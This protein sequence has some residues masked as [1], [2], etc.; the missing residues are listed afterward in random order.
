MC[1]LRELVSGEATTAPSVIAAPNMP[2]AMTAAQANL[3]LQLARH[4][5]DIPCPSLQLMFAGDLSHS[6]CNC[7]ITQVVRFAHLEC[8]GVRHCMPSTTTINGRRPQAC[9]SIDC[10]SE[11]RGQKARPRR[12]H[13]TTDSAKTAVTPTL[14]K[15]NSLPEDL[16]RCARPKALRISQRSADRRPVEQ[17]MTESAPDKQVIVTCQFWIFPLVLLPAQPSRPT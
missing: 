5:I 16:S 9:A 4:C 6:A 1:T 14:T 7:L 12:R 8:T 13:S 10:S 11:C 17:A 15:R 2:I 3:L